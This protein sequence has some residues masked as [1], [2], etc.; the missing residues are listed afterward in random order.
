[1]RTTPP[2]PVDLEVV[3]VPAGADWR[4]ALARHVRTPFDLST[5]PLH[6]FA[7]LRIGPEEHVLSVVLHHIVSDGWSMG[8]VHADLAALYASGGSELPAVSSY[9]R[10]AERQRAAADADGFAAGLDHWEARLAG[11]PGLDLP[12]DRLRPAVQTFRG[13]TVALPLPAQLHAAARATAREQG[14]SLFMVLCAAVGAVLS[15]YTGAVD[16]PIGTAVPGRGEKEL[17]QVGLFAN[18]VVLRLDLDGD[19]AFADVLGRVAEVLLDAHDHQHVPFE[20]V[21]DRLRPARDQSRNPLFQVAVQL[22]GQQTSGTGLHLPG[23][24]ATAVDLPETGSRFDLSLTF[25]E[26]ADSLVLNVEYASDL[27]DRWRVEALAGHVAQVLTAACADPATRLSA[28]SPLT[29]AERAD[30]LS[31]GRGAPLEHGPEPVHTLISRGAALRPDHPAA[32]CAGRT[33]TY[34]ELDQRSTRLAARLRASGVG[35]GTVVGVAMQR[36]VDVLVA[37]LGVLKADAA[38]VVLDPTHPRARLEFM[39]EETGAPVVCTQAR[40]RD[41]LPTGAWELLAVDE[42]W[43]GEV[44]DVQGVATRD[45]LAYVLYTSGSTGR[46]KGV[47]IEHRALISFVESYRRRF[48]ITPD[49]RMLQL[50]ALAF[51]MSQGE[52]FSALVS[53]ATLVQVPGNVGRSPDAL[54]DLMRAEEVTYICFSP[55]MLSLVEPGPY[56]HLR[57]IMAGGEALP[58]ETVNRWNRPGRRLLNVYGPTEAA[59]G[60]TDYECPHEPCTAAPPIGRPHPDRRVYVVDRYDELVPRGVPGELLIGGDEGL[61]RG[62]LDRP[63]LTAQRFV[64]DPFHPG[65]RVYRS[66]DLA[67]WNADDQLEFLG[68]LDNQVKLRGLR[69]ELEEI[70]S[71][72]LAHPQ[73][74]MAAVAVRPGLGG[75]PRLV[76][77]VTAAGAT[78]PT[79]AALAEHAATRLPEYMVPPQWVVLDRFPLT[80][81][82]KIDRAALPAP[83]P[84]PSADG[85]GD[86]AATPTERRV[87]AVVAEVLDVGSVSVTDGFFQAGGSSLQAM[88]V[89]GRLNKE[90]GVALTMRSLYGTGGVRA[91]AATV[92]GMLAADDS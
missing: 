80:T 21:V 62:Y 46:P 87:A 29:P 8:L 74:E 35:H 85:P 3:D 26:S 1:M 15:R 37:L 30:L 61:A 41:G 5:G 23:I 67:R 69:I 43:D 25:A 88:R 50:A 53:G 54:A 77:Y 22:L 84:E 7:L 13:G 38:F 28:L 36:D 40:L 11:L 71:V 90:F 60:C 10:F 52:I 4:D 27:F 66:G 31:V 65:G 39:L 32:V 2:G 75:D 48:A 45:S 34:G 47:L 68:R 81:A 86:A 42:P 24:A 82:R 78:A 16:V 57:K 63:D 79:A 55:A 91:V 92:D 59:V 58:A 19:P 56:P 20:R 44:P 18:M 89:I 83:D 64:P 72:L 12:A 76:G 51:D 49:D 6:R 17:E 73:V 33:L 14:T 9:A 70:E